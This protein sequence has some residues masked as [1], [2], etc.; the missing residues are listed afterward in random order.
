MAA[1]W[2]QFGTFAEDLTLTDRIAMMPPYPAYVQVH[3]VGSVITSGGNN[4]CPGL[5]DGGIVGACLDPEDS[6]LTFGAQCGSA[7]FEFGGTATSGQETNP[8]PLGFVDAEFAGM[9]RRPVDGDSYAGDPT[10]DAYRTLIPWA[11]FVANSVAM[12]TMQATHAHTATRRNTGASVRLWWL[13]SDAPTPPTAVAYVG[14][15]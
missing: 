8:A 9:L 13:E 15:A 6:E 1:R 2:V 12:I 5:T 10:N 11:E 3:V 14:A 7:A 4:L